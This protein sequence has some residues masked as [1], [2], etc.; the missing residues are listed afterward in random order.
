[1][2]S[3]P[4][5][6]RSSSE[7]EQVPDD[8]TDALA[9]VSQPLPGSRPAH[10]VPYLLPTSTLPTYLCSAH[11]AA[12]LT[13]QVPVCKVGG[14]G[15]PS[16][17]GQER[18]L[19]RRTSCLPARALPVPPSVTQHP[20]SSLPGRRDLTKLGAACATAGRSN[21]CPL[22]SPHPSHPQTAPPPPSSLSAQTTIF[23]VLQTPARRN[24][25]NTCRHKSPIPPP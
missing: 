4:C 9:V 14:S 10:S 12:A 1:M 18:Y 21:H 6:W 7:R 3:C 8:C 5:R 16:F 13:L 23:R 25:P 11:L 2:E 24:R 20:S 17:G 22:T 19:Q 15:F